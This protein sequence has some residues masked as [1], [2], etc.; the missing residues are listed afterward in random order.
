[1]QISVNMKKRI[2]II[3]LLCAVVFSMDSANAQ[4]KKKKRTTHGVVKKGKGKKRKGGKKVVVIPPPPS[5]PSAPMVVDTPKKVI[6]AAVS[7]KKFDR[8]VD[9]YYKKNNILNAKVKPYPYLREVDVAYSKRVWR[10]ID[11]REKMNQYLASPRARLIDVIMEGVDS[12]E[13]TAY[14][15]TA[16]PEDPD[17]DAF[18]HP[19]K[20][21]AAHSKLAD[22]SLVD[23]F[24]KVTGDKTG[25]VLTPG[26]FN[27]DSLVKFRIK[28]DWIFDKQRSVF[29][30][31][32]I[33]IA[34]LT[35]PK[36]QG[37]A[38]IADY[39]PAF[40]IYMPEARALFARKEVSS[41]HTD[42]SGLSFDDVFVK[43]IFTSYITKVSSDND[44]RIKDSFTG[45]DKLYESE[46]IKKSLQ[47]WEINLWQY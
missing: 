1:M 45:I 3:F 11:L 22:S 33:G 46:R 47:D 26:Q 18:A 7:V 41:K 9:G 17:G 32:I 35:K 43:R 34:P 29:E 20:P 36:D 16:G 44:L 27:P 38:A 21:S 8:P 2:L 23:Q 14:D 12:G 25:S 4:S 24:D 40:W 5:L 42:A 39:Q 19:L 6:V 37:L 15:A 13:L 31:R 28:E 10:D 30:P